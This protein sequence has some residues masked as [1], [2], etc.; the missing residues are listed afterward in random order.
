MGRTN[1]ENLV[2]LSMA[3][4]LASIGICDHASCQTQMADSR[5]AHQ[6]MSS[7]GPSVEKEIKLGNAYL[8]GQG[9]NK[10]EKLAAYWFRK[11]AEAGD[12]W[13]EQQLGFFYQAGIGVPI[14][15]ARA[16]HWYQLAA[17]G[18]LVSAKTNLGVA[19]LWGIGVSMDKRMAEQ[20]FREAAKK[21]DGTAATYLGTLYHS[22]G[23]LNKD[24]A[25]AEHWYMVGAK[26][27]DPVADYDLGTLYS[28][29][30]HPH[31]FRRAAD[32]LR[33]SVA[34]GYVPAIHSLGLLLESHPE[35]AK[36]GHEYL[37]L[38]QEASGYGQWRS[39][40]AL[41]ILH[42]E[43]KLVPRDPKA[44]YYYF[45]LAI[46][47]GAEAPRDKLDHVMQVTSNE[48]GTEQAA[49]IEAVARAWY[50]QHHETLEFLLK[51]TGKGAPPGLAI[52]TPETGTHAGRIIPAPRASLMQSDML[53]PS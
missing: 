44:A 28:V 33:K 48:L 23:V 3:W 22:G 43:G 2:V 14:D 21:G 41:A 45:Q 11:A 49:K 53:P 7:G 19:Y 30:D 8:S 51:K 35:V 32:W 42:N 20:L 26:L 6:M 37:T 38:L 34:G 29:E 15:P 47:Q 12:P 25:A 9:A 17:A 10:D 24:E 31:D 46:L 52:V 50:E 39:S 1:R 4:V 16:A 40:M 18:G 13:A 27:H 36:S 5:G